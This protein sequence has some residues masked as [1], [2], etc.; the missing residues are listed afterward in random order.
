MN[1]CLTCKH[2][3]IRV[4]ARGIDWGECKRMR[5]SEKR[6]VALGLAVAAINIQADGLQ[7]IATTADFGC[8]LWEAK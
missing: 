2:W 8:A 3:R 7:D 1:T 6:R 4:N 5:S